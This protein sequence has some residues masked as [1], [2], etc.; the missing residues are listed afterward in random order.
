MLLMTVYI[1][2]EIW[3]LSKTVPWCYPPHFK[4]DSQMLLTV[5]YYPKV[6]LF[7]EVNAR[8]SFDAGSSFILFV[9]LTPLYS[10]ESIK[11]HLIWSLWL[12]RLSNPSH[13][14]REQISVLE[15]LM[16]LQLKSK[17]HLPSF[18][19]WFP[20]FSVKINF[21]TFGIFSVVVLYNSH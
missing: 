8:F 10:H 21:Q 15:R 16:E 19:L 3:I 13:F 7:V 4:L 9:A 11:L 12:Q 2:G 1:L 20:A 5:C 17:L 14:S 6:V 18:C